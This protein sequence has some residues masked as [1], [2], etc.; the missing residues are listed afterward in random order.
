MATKKGISQ[1]GITLDKDHNKPVFGQGGRGLA[2]LGTDKRP[3]A[4]GGGQPDQPQPSNGEDAGAG[5]RFVWEDEHLIFEGEGGASEEDLQTEAPLPEDQQQKQKPVPP[6][7]QTSLD[8]ARTRSESKYEGKADFGRIERGLDELQLDAQGRLANVIEK[9]RE[10]LLALIARKHAAGTITTDF[11]QTLDLKHKAEL[12]RVA[13]SFL[14][15]AYRNGR[16]EGRSMLPATLQVRVTQGIPPE[17]ALQFF[18]DKAFWI[19]GVYKDQ[20]T[21]AARAIL[22]NS[23]KTGEPTGTTI[24]KLRDAFEPYLGDP[25][26]ID[27]ESL[28]Q[29][30]PYRLETIVRTN[31]TEAFNEGLKDSLDPEVQDGYIIGWEYSAILDSRTTDVCRYLDGKIF[32]PDSASFQ[33]MTPPNHFNCRS[34]IIPITKDEGPVRFITEQEIGRAT[35]LKGD[36]F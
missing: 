1:E 24:Q 9:Q 30:Q 16:T 2:I 26:A 36:Q 13:R 22:F 35:D 27:P 3:P 17:D 10:S 28:A 25:D 23:I 33:Y 29:A 14:Q 34:T 21:N 7:T 6:K 20:L 8:Y 32:R 31:T 11:I 18:E 15:E 12:F 19:S 4:Q 5:S